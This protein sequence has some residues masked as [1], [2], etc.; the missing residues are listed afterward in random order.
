[1]SSKLCKTRTVAQL[2]SLTLLIHSFLYMAERDF[3]L[4]S[5]GFFKVN[6]IAFS[7]VYFYSAELPLTLILTQ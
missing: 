6:P 3:R 2:L 1:M 5:E 4:N 7:C